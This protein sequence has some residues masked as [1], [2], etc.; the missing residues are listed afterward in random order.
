MKDVFC[1]LGF[2]KVL[3]QINTMD[4]YVD[5]KDSCFCLV[6]VLTV[7]MR[8]FLNYT[9]VPLFEMPVVYFADL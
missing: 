1:S 2:Q 9:P 5:E 7:F 4:I 8:F 6:H 3:L